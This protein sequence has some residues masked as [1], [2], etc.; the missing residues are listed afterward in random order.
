M[1]TRSDLEP[2]G[3]EQGGRV[4][5]LRPRVPAAARGE[6]ALSPGRRVIYVLLLALWLVVV[7][8]FW[9]FWARPEFRGALA[10]WI[11]ATFAFA[12]LLTGLPSIYWF[13]VGRMRR[14]PR[15][16]APPGRRVAMITLC[17]P[18]HESIDVIE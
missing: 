14:A 15:V 5:A 10:L 6:P 4:A 1:E 17:V 13:Y 11:P 7:A 3:V 9:N 2:A 8:R 16:P 18:S 12:Y